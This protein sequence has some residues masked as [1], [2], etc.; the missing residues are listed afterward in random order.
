MTYAWLTSD[1][2][3]KGSL[4]NVMNHARLRVLS[5]IGPF[6]I[7]QDGDQ[8]AGPASRIKILRRFRHILEGCDVGSVYRIRNAH[9]VLF[10]SRKVEEAVHIIETSGNLKADLCWTLVKGQFPF[11]DFLGAYVCKHIAGT[12]TMSQHSYGNAIDFGGRNMDD[13]NNI[14]LWVWNHREELHVHTIIYANQVWTADRGWHPYT[15][16]FHY[17]VHVDFDPPQSGSCGVRG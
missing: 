9:R 11:V 2:W 7:T 5:G 3:K 14:R 13:L 6:T 8:V 17:H 16:V 12:S 15:G 10:T 1:G 4:D